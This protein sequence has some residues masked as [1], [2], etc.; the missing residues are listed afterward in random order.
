[1]GWSRNDR[2]IGSSESSQRGGRVSQLRQDSPRETKPE[3]RRPPVPP[4]AYQTQEEEEEEEEEE[5]DKNESSESSQRGRFVSQLQ[6]GSP[7]ETKPERRR[8]PL[9]P[10]AYE[11]PVSSAS[12][13]DSRIGTSTSGSGQKNAESCSKEEGEDKKDFK[14]DEEPDRETKQ[15]RVDDYGVAPDFPWTLMQA[16]QR[17]LSFPLLI[18]QSN[19]GERQKPGNSKSRPCKLESP[20][21]D[22]DGDCCVHE[23]D[24]PREEE[25]PVSSIGGFVPPSRGGKPLSAQP[26]VLVNHV[27]PKTDQPRRKQQRNKKRAN[28]RLE[29]S[30]DDDDFSSDKGPSP[31]LPSRG[32]SARQPMSPPPSPATPQYGLLQLPLSRPTTPPVPSYCQISSVPSTSAGGGAVEDGQA[33]LE[34]GALNLKK[35]EQ[36]LEKGKKK[37]EKNKA[38]QAIDR[39]ELEWEQEPDCDPF[40]RELEQLKPKDGPEEAEEEGAPG[41]VQAAT[42][43]GLLG[44][45]ETKE[46]KRRVEDANRLAREASTRYQEALEPQKRVRTK[47]DLPRRKEL[48]FLRREKELAEKELQLL[49]RE[50]RCQEERVMYEQEVKAKKE[51]AERLDEVLKQKASELEDLKEKQAGLNAATVQVLAVGH[52]IHNTTIQ[53]IQEGRRATTV[54][55]NGIPESQVDEEGT[56]SDEWEL[57]QQALHHAKVA[58]GTEEQDSA[59]Q[60][61]PVPELSK[62]W[63]TSLQSR[64][65]QQ[66]QILMQSN[67]QWFEENSHKVEKDDRLRLHTELEKIEHSLDVLRD[68]ALEILTGEVAETVLLMERGSAEERKHLTITQVTGEGGDELGAVAATLASTSGPKK[69]SQAFMSGDLE[70]ASPDEDRVETAEEGSSSSEAPTLV[71]TQLERLKNA[72]SPRQENGIQGSA[73]S[74]FAGARQF[75]IHHATFINSELTTVMTPIN[76]I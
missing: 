33:T 51:E 63:R 62:R 6:Q 58:P 5:E 27:S 9:P 11:T 48:E 47:A 44:D 35:L 32:G 53:S 24:S 61:T 30:D 15:V 59:I 7:R 54:E 68:F 36:G 29:A 19:P 14:D 3:R 75:V 50:L 71:A 56:W 39:S 67:R 73:V 42:N 37:W 65:D 66:V 38:K 12:Q 34:T 72:N 43:S 41:L 4:G 74:P 1:M 18:G 8:P 46:L 76:A 25:L 40:G 52:S 28:Y 64:I 17:V 55:A 16:A 20:F 70:E 2:D 13:R 57:G 45:E 31:P 23:G 26:S 21:F 49:E 10:R 69:E 60:V 22:L